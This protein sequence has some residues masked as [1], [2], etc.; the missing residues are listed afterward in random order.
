MGESKQQGC[1]GGS[2]QSGFAPADPLDGRDIGK[3]QTEYPAEARKEIKVEAYYTGV[4][5]VVYFL[6][7]VISL[8]ISD[9][10]PN[11][12]AKITPDFHGL[13]SNFLGYL[14][15][16]FGG[17]LG[18]SLYAVKWMYHV[19]ARRS[20]HQ[21]RRL[22]RIFTPHISAAL[23][24]IVVLVASSD[25]LAVFDAN[26]I[27]NHEQILVMAILAGLF[28]DKA[29]AKLSEVANT[30]FGQTEKPQ[31]YLPQDPPLPQEPGQN[32]KGEG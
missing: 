25:T 1:E 5:A 22:W 16:I 7:V 14:C 12:D 31:Q 29:L 13:S 9:K 17:G 24:L 2:Y 6:A 3:W 11:G 8:W 21:D 32:Q 19:V 15:A 23:A 26:L 4:C 27:Q 30:L 28:S 10:F 18:G 20:W